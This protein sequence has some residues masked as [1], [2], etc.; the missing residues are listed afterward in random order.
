MMIPFPGTVLRREKRTGWNLFYLMLA[1]TEHA[2]EGKPRMVASAFVNGD[3]V[4]NMALAQIFERPKEMLRGDAEHR[5]ADANA[6]IERD[7]FV[8]L[9]FLAEAIDEVDFGANGPFGACRG[10]L[11][12]LDDAFRRA[13]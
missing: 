7:D 11:D 1:Q 12:G 10:G 13:Y 4:H 9:Q 6:G 8:A 2:V 3:A 5:S